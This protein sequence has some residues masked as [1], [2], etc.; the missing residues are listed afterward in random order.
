MVIQPLWNLF[1][2]AHSFGVSISLALFSSQTLSFW[3]VSAHILP[4]NARKEKERVFA[5]TCS[6]R[7]TP[8]LEKTFQDV[9]LVTEMPQFSHVM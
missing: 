5:V 6:G 8:M 7:V 2:N 4:D 1:F 9:S 3:A